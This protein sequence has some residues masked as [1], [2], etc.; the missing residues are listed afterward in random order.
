MGLAISEQPEGP[1][2]I[3]DIPVTNNTQ[4]IEDG[5]A[6][7]FEDDI[8][9]LTTDNHG[10][11]GTPGEG[12]LWRSSDGKTFDRREKGFHLITRYTKIVQAKV[13][14]HYGPDIIKFERPQLLLI[15]GDP[16]YLYAPGGVNI[17]G[18]S[19]TISYV[20]KFNNIKE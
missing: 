18:G 8:C 1:Y 13:L 15:D 2:I 6:F 4:S 19:G 5:Y 17:F 20:L 11:M 7:I 14:R 3:E 16:A 9:L 12:I 10:I